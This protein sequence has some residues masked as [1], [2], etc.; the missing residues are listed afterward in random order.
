MGAG[1]R[2]HEDY[3]ANGDV[4]GEQ[5]VGGDDGADGVGVQVE[6][7]FVEGSV[8]DIS[9]TDNLDSLHSECSSC[10]YLD[11]YIQDA[12]SSRNKE[13][14]AMG[15]R[16]VRLLAE[17][18]SAAPLTICRTIGDSHSGILKLQRSVLRSRF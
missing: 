15:R 17:M 2:G 10:K 16:T 8:V 11:K 6:G 14:S 3:G 5:A 18:F 12:R 7:E 1:V 13:S 4:G 9:I